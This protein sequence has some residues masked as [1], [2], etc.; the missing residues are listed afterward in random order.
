[1]SIGKPVMTVKKKKIIQ[2]SKQKKFYKG[3]NIFFEPN[4][5]NDFITNI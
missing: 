4:E 2:E 3:K 5:I 1:M